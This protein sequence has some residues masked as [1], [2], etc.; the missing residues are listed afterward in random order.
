MGNIEGRTWYQPN[1]NVNLGNMCFKGDK[2]Q[3]ASTSALSDNYKCCRGFNDGTAMGLNM[4][5]DTTLTTP[6]N[7]YGVTYP[8]ESLGDE[9][10][11]KSPIK[12]LNYD[13]SYAYFSKG[14]D[15]MKMSAVVMSLALFIQL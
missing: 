1:G 15:K 6:T 2:C 10:S 14:A 13:C 5:V 8:Y 3:N 7:S 12:Q 9:H 4:C 11:A